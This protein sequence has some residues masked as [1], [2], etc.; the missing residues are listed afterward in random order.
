[1]LINYVFFFFPKLINIIFRKNQ[2]FFTFLNLNTKFSKTKN[3]MNNEEDYK[4]NSKIII[5]KCFVENKFSK[6]EF[7]LIQAGVN[8]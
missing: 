8:R 2:K 7:E 6:D 4:K 5:Q 3:I 1:M